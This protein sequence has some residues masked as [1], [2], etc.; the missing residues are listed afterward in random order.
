MSAL[1]ASLP[2]IDTTKPSKA[3]A[4]SKLYREPE[5]EKFVN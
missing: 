5:L 3:R 4:S 1:A 2:K